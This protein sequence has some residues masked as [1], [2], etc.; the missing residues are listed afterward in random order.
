MAGDVKQNAGHVRRVPQRT[1]VGC[2]Q[3]LAKRSL[4]R[5]VRTPNG[6]QLDRTG[7][8]PG[9]GAYLHNQ[10]SCWTRALKG[11]LAAALRTQFGPEDL[12]YLQGILAGLPEEAAGESHESGAF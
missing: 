4:M 7:K 9:R 3:V 2:H 12:T 8:M 1:C 10:R 6:V 11:P 5:L